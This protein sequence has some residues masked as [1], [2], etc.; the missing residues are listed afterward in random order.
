MNLG[1]EV[2]ASGRRRSTIPFL[3]TTFA[4]NYP[5]FG[6]TGGFSGDGGVP[7]SAAFLNC[8][9]ITL[10]TA[11]NVY[12][13][14][15][16]NNRIRVVNMQG[17]TQTLF[18]V[19]VG[20]GKVQ[21]IV[22][23]SSTSAYGGDG[24]PATSALLGHPAYIAFDA[25]GN[26]YIG[27]QQNAAIRKVTT[28]GVISTVVGGARGHMSNGLTPG[29]NQPAKFILSAVANASAGNTVYTGTFPQTLA[30]GEGLYIQGF[31]NSANNGWFTVVGTGTSTNVTL[32]NASGVAET[33]AATANY[34]NLNFPQ[35]IA[36]D[37]AGNLIIADAFNHLIRVYNTQVTTQTF[38]GTSIA[39]GFVKAI[40]GRSNGATFTPG[41]SG[42]GGPATS[43]FLWNPVTATVGPD[44]GLYITDWQ[45]NV[46]RRVS[47][48]GTISTWAGTNGTI[49]ITGVSAT[50][51]TS[52][53]SYTGSIVL[54]STYNSVDNGIGIIV[55]GCPSSVNNG[56]FAVVSVAAGTFTVNNSNTGVTE[57]TPGAT[58]FLGVAGYGGDSGQATSAIMYN[59]QDVRFDSN[60]NALIV[61]ASNSIVRKVTPGGVISTIAGNVSLYGP[62]TGAFAG[63][64]GL[65]TSGGMNT[66]IGLYIDNVNNFIYVGEFFSNVVRKLYPDIQPAPTVSSLSV[67]S[68]PAS[69]GTATTITGTGFVA[70][71]T[72]TIGGAQATSVVVASSVSITCV[73]PAGSVGAA[74]VVVTNLDTKFGTL[75]NGFTYIASA[76]LV[77]SG[78]AG[79]HGS[80]AQVSP[81]VLNTTGATLLIAVTAAFFNSNVNTPGTI[82][83]SISGGSNVWHPLTTYKST[84][85][86]GTENTT[87]YYAFD[88]TGGGSLLTGASHSFTVATGTGDASVSVYAVA[89]TLTSASV[90]DIETGTNGPLSSPFQPGSLTPTLGDVVVTGFSNGTTSSSCSIA[91]AGSDTAWSTP[92]RLINGNDGGAGASILLYAS[93]SALNP[94]WTVAQ[95]GNGAAIACF[96][97]A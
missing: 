83:D 68:G 46:I 73:T 20:S 42:D 56:P 71:A 75:T 40:A 65:A 4:G 52:V 96:K 57:S 93:G 22:G 64:G 27:D 34:T 59:P 14:D 47:P 63:D 38:F 39:P 44:G 18:N 32:N 91:G 74:N 15:V 50:G 66:P 82:S 8:G 30:N 13:C 88:R 35:G 25:S 76:T 86:G 7:T 67:A 21:T 53:Y 48:T 84:A 36:V 77:A 97:K 62:P 11:G 19:S 41:Y 26:M 70:G 1:L 80:G 69:G 37:A 72:V 33:R 61:E 79:L 10:D 17:T 90:F 81:L 5:L 45:N 12:I 49:Q 29:D 92:F 9:G 95:N 94:T 78:M 55:S 28:A 85:T 87:I 51:T 54:P 31:T 43:A 23:S 2:L 60:G 6:Q 16:E 3:I 89:G 58:G 24:G